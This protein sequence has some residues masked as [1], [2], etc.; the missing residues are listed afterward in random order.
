[1]SANIDLKKEIEIT[2]EMEIAG[3]EAL[4][5]HLRYGAIGIARDVAREVFL[6]M[7]DKRPKSRD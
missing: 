2:S 1:M 5:S 3:A 7:N 4:Q 6:A